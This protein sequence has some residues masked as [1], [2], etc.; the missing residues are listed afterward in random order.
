MLVDGNV[1]SLVTL[2][3]DS[4]SR[5]FPAQRFSF[6]LV[7]GAAWRGDGPLVA[8]LNGVARIYLSRPL[9]PSPR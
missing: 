6:L 9:P 4:A 2:L 1:M 7:D 5:P 8:L 3:S